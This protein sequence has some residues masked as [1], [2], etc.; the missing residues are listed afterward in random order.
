MKRRIELGI[1]AIDPQGRP[2]TGSLYSAGAKVYKTEGMARAAVSRHN[3][4]DNYSFVPAFV[5]IEME[6]EKTLCEVCGQNPCADNCTIF[7]GTWK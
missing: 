6:V 1:V 3:R 7:D 5:E 4:K 2:H